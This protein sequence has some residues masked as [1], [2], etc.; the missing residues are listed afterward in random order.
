MYVYNSNTTFPNPSDIYFLSLLPSSTVCAVKPYILTKDILVML[1]SAILNRLCIEDDALKCG[2]QC[3]KLSQYFETQLDSSSS[4]S[5]ALF[6][7]ISYLNLFSHATC[8][9]D[10]VITFI[11]V[12]SK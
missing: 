7:D 11:A 4:G 5:T 2:L 3:F 12:V 8:F 6:V 9:Q 1:L 10:I